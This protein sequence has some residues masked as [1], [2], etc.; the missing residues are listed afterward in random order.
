MIY[1]IDDGRHESDITI[2]YLCYVLII[3]RLHLCV[4]HNFENCV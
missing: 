2:N 1:S 3:R 4:I